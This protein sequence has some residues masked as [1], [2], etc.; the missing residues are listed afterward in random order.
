VV[1]VLKVNLGIG[2]GLGQ[3]KQNETICSAF[4]YLSAVKNNQLVMCALNILLVQCSSA[5]PKS[6][7]VQP[8]N[9]CMQANSN[10]LF[11]TILERS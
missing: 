9:P 7:F 8:K 10:A 1:V 3:A 2:F 4:Y 6:I 11:E 5:L